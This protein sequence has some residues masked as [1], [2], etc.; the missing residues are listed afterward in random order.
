MF[1]K[2]TLKDPYGI[3]KC[4]EDA[5]EDNFVDDSSLMKEEQDEIFEKRVIDLQAFIS[6]WI[7]Y[8]DYIVL[9]FD[10]NKNTCTVEEA[11][12]SIKEC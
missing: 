10:T 2:I 12:T 8:D 3:K 6:K 5:I 4:L 11:V 9:V 7:C 1:F